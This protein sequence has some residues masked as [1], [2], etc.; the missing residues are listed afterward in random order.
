MLG[1]SIYFLIQGAHL[2]RSNR[3]IKKLLQPGMEFVEFVWWGEILYKI[4]IDFMSF[5][6]CISLVY[7]T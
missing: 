1:L 7:P 6:F 2:S 3:L 4:L 5:F